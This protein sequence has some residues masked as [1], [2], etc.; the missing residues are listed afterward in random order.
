[1]RLFRALYILMILCPALAT[2]AE[3]KGTRLVGVGVLCFDAP[4][5]YTVVM[6]DSLHDAFAGY[7]EPLDHSWRVKWYIGLWEK[8]LTPKGGRKIVWQREEEVHGEK[9]AAGLVEDKE[10][11]RL[12]LSNGKLQ[13]TIP[14]DTS[15]ALGVLKQVAAMVK[16]RKEGDNCAPPNREKRESF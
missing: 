3:C 11:R 4:C 14:S 7:I 13:L 1:M 2:A 6:N 9:W 16:Y 15:D 10:E 12:V 8:L 5:E